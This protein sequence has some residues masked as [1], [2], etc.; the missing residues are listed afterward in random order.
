MEKEK[1]LTSQESLDLIARMIGKAKSD[2]IDT[3]ISAL[4]WGSIISFCGLV[5][6]ANYYI[7][8]EWLN[9][10]WLLSIIAVIPQIIISARERKKRR[11]KRYEDDLM[12]GIWI[13]FGCSM[14]LL[15]YFEGVYNLSH[16]NSIFLV[17]YGIPTFAT[18]YGRRF[19]PMIIG[20]IA[21]WVFAILCAYAPA[22]YQMLYITAGA[23]L[24]W[25]IPGLILRKAYLN[26][27]PQHV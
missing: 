8:W 6:F 23:Q 25:F 7:G 5:S 20:G 11:H 26:A 22:P 19:K 18:G 3:G 13:S 14:F 10:V 16:S 24:A 21:C 1:E 4:L 17:V 12:G 9:W 27:K 15:S 2:Y